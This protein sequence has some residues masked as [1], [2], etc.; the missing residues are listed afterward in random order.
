MKKQNNYPS[1]DYG[2]DEGYFDDETTT[3]SGKDLSVFENKISQIARF[4]LIFKIRG[5]TRPNH[6]T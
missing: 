6:Q 1:Y 3:H 2:Y 5:A 4:F